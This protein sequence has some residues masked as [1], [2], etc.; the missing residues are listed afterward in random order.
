[1]PRGARI[2]VPLAIY[3][4]SCLQVSWAIGTNVRS[5][6][7]QL[8]ARLGTATRPPADEAAAR[9]AGLPGGSIVSGS[10][11]ESWGRLVAE[12]CGTRIRCPRAQYPYMQLQVYACSRLQR[13]PPVIR[14][15]P[16][17]YARL[18]AEM[19]KCAGHP[20][21]VAERQYS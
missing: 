12:R 16:A 6:I 10:G 4:G 7:N 14:V 11:N 2:T 18:R 1:M 9:L 20:S 8:R 13:R 21:Q 3:V 5:R 15:D 19:E 17:N